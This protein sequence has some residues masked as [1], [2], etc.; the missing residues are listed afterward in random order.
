MNT[1]LAILLLVG[2]GAF[3]YAA[4]V[5]I[6]GKVLHRDYYGAKVPDRVVTDPRLRATANRAF[7]VWCSA[8][9]LLLVA[10]IV[11][12]FSDFARERT[13]SELA[14]L[15]A[16]VFVAVVVGGYPFEKIKNL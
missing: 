2:L 9:A 6:R 12:L 1:V 3:A 14:F 11:W 10:P 8:G 5:G 4:S 7:T 13:V 15:A 16:Y